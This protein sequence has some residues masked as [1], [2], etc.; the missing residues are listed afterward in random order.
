M[1]EFTIPGEP[2]A[3]QRHRDNGRGG[4]YDPSAKDK[5]VFLI[6]SMRYAPKEPF[7]FPLRVDIDF[8]FE[9]PKCHYETRKAVKGTLKLTSPKWHINIPDRD[10]V[11]KFLMDALSGVFW[12]DD[13]IVCDG[14][15]T[16][17]YSSNPRTEISIMEAE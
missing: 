14:N 16:K 3:L 1:I 7:D 11:E 12:K 10:N 4:K 5:Q 9:R 6:N 17:Q 8:Y 13:R 15:I 2:K